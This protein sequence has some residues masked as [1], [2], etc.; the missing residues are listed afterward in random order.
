MSSTT[1]ST[2]LVISIGEMGLRVAKLLLAESSHS[3]NTEG[4]RYDDMK[5]TIIA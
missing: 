4:I 1:I 5:Q 2:V 3:L